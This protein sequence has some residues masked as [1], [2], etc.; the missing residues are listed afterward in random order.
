MPSVMDRLERVKTSTWCFDAFTDWPRFTWSAA[1]DLG[2]WLRWIVDMQHI[3][4][5]KWRRTLLAS[6]VYDVNV[7]S[8]ELTPLPNVPVV[9]FCNEPF[10]LFSGYTNSF[11]TVYNLR[12]S[13]LPI[14]VSMTFF[15]FPYGFK[16]SKHAQFSFMLFCTASVMQKNETRCYALTSMFLLPKAMFCTIPLWPVFCTQPW[17]RQGNKHLLKV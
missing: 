15:P 12:C 3:C 13:T 11:L 4:L 9:T 8:G 10:R 16:T 5:A 17:L 1:L 7:E 6:N 14:S 2:F